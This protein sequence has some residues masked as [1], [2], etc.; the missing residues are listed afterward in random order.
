MA[1]VLEERFRVFWHSRRGG[2]PD[3]QAGLMNAFR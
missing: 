1:N 2:R 3:Q